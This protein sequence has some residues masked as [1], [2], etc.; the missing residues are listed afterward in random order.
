MCAD[1]RS[2]ATAYVF[3]SLEWWHQNAEGY[4]GIRNSFASSWP[5]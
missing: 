1:L 4:G 2:C 5:M 3:I